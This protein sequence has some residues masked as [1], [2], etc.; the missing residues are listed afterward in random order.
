MAVRHPSASATVSDVP[1][2]D[3]ERVV[4]PGLARALLE[5]RVPELRG[6]TIERLAEGWDNVV[7]LV[8]GRWVA[9]CT[10]RGG[11]GAGPRTNRSPGSAESG[12]HRDEDRRPPGLLPSGDRNVAV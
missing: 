6:T 8:G 1:E 10:A 9:R 7:Y 2:W 3:P 12:N 5:A 11:A 4:D